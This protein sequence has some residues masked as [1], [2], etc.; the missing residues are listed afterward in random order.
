[1]S[2][3]HLPDPKFSVRRSWR[4]L[5]LCMVAIL[6][7]ACTPVTLPSDLQV[8]APEET[9]APRQEPVQA[10][11][12]A[13][14]DTE[15]LMAL[16]FETVPLRNESTDGF[17]GIN[18]IPAQN[19]AF[20][21]LWIVHTYGIRPFEPLTNHFVALY[22][23]DGGEWVE[24]A[25]AEPEC[26]DYVDANGIGEVAISPDSLWIEHHG[27][28]GAH[29]GCF[30]LLRWD[31]GEFS[32]AAEGFNSSPGA[33]SVVDVDG[34]GQLD[35]I[36]N[37]TDPYVFCYACGARL[38]GAQIL[39]WDGSDLVPV[40]LET[41]PESA[42][43]DLRSLNDRAV[44][45]AKASLYADA[46]P[47]IQQALAL[48]PD[49]EQVY[50]NA[51]EIE[52]YAENRLDF[53]ANGAYPLLGY[54]FYGDYAAAVEE[55]R[56][57]SPEQIFDLESPLIVGTA[58][59]GWVEQLSGYLISFAGDALAVQ[60]DLA[61]AHFLRAWGRFLADP[62]DPGVSED[63]NRAAQLAPDDVLFA[64]SAAYLQGAT[65]PPTAT[66][67]SREPTVPA[68]TNI[69]FAPG[70]TAE[71]LHVDLQNSPEQTYRLEVAAGQSVYV[72]APGDISTELHSES[73]V[74]QP[75]LQPGGATEYGIAAGGAYFLTVRGNRT[76]DILVYIP[77]ANPDPNPPSADHIQQIRF[78]PGAT[79][80]TVDTV[81][82]E[83]TAQGFVLGIGARQSL[84]VFASGN[85]SLTLLDPQG[86]LLT[87]VSVDPGGT[88]AYAIP[89]SGD[90]TIVLRGNGPVSLVIEIPPL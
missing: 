82:S 89:F 18:V 28:A 32:F 48:A 21:P 15:G 76:V 17:D 70:A 69:R 52:L 71:L 59:E 35:V 37:G 55:M 67:D 80:A 19:E 66:P 65:P 3:P 34:D 12:L 90:Y 22:Q 83:N 74:P 79:G 31:G 47:L 84:F 16:L 7:A 63:V 77:P 56:S 30:A 4:A 88:V 85:S 8:L 62:G 61:E 86:R 2:I 25:R 78:A 14:I 26:A 68:A 11:D 24:I 60:P 51:Q 9:P 72:T 39:R 6:M 42:P 64:E 81:L 36:L 44:V 23:H 13:T 27:G 57:L 75:A 1:M 33:G 41:L 10:Q 43:A 53:A 54:V 46:L 45:L 50:W 5:A 58:A 49:N 38:Y 87:P 73:G 29:S 20:G 40:R